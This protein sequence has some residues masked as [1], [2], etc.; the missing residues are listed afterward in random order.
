MGWVLITKRHGPGRQSTTE[1]YV[2]FKKA[3]KKAID[4]YLENMDMSIHNAFDGPV[5]VEWKRVR[6]LPESVHRSKVRE[7][8]CDVEYGTK[9]LAVLAKTKTCKEYEWVCRGCGFAWSRPF[10]KCPRSTSSPKCDGKLRRRVR[11][12]K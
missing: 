12:V 5:M 11:A 7:H 8:T 1:K 3:T 4:D 9:M 2:Y 6:A 10:K